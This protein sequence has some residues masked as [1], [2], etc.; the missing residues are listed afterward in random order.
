M[1]S[2]EQI[3]A[4]DQPPS[5]PPELPWTQPNGVS[6]KYD[7][8]CHCGAIRLSMKLSPPL[9]EEQTQGKEQCVAVECNC[10]HCERHGY[11]A[12][13]PLQKDVEWIQ[14][15]EHRGE[16]RMGNKVCP[17]YFCK[18]CG[19]VLATDLTFL[20]ENILKMENRYTINVSLFLSISLR[21]IF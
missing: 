11:W 5:N 19:C 3:S 14:G 7:L 13:H 21:Y 1:S 2:S 20:M 12:V 4:S 9:Y 8:H 16:Y 17:H 10:S 18:L 15:L 6:Q